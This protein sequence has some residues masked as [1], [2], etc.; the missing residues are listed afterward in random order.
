MPTVRLDLLANAEQAVWVTEQGEIIPFGLEYD[1]RGYVLYRYDVTMED[2]KSYPVGLETHPRWV[3]DGWIQGSFDTLPHQIEAGDELVVTVGFRS[4]AV[5][6]SGVR[7]RVVGGFSSGLASVPPPGKGILLG[8]ALERNL[9]WPWQPQRSAAGASVPPFLSPVAGGA[10]MPLAG[11][12]GVLFEAIETYDGKLTTARIPLDTWVGYKVTFGLQV[13]A[14]GD[15]L[16][17]WA[18]WVVA[19]VEK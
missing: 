7:F 15:P 12:Y 3:M 10:A 2:G 1:E 18:T 16:A 9:V 14:L 17:D 8:T 6:T 5:Q 19:R 4:G 13:E 11:G